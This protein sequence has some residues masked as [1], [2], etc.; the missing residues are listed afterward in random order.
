MKKVLTI[1]VVLTLIAGAA[2]AAMT[3]GNKVTLTT[4]IA[5]LDPTYQ[6]QVKQANDTY[7]ASDR[8]VSSIADA[9]V[10]ADFKVMQVGDARLATGRVITVEVTCGAF[11]NSADQTVT[12]ELPSVAAEADADVRTNLSFSVAAD[13]DNNVVTFKPQYDGYVAAG[14][15]GSFTA[16]WAKRADLPSGTYTADITLAYTTI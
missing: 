11:K 4:E 7:S 5:Q 3:D 10:S 12:T 14:E 1:L 9:A 15:I 13:S 8:S 2:F 16:S 6:L